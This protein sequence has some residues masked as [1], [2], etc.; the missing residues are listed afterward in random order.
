LVHVGAERQ[1]IDYGRRLKHPTLHG[2][3]S[4]AGRVCAKPTSRLAAIQ[5]HESSNV[6]SY[7]VLRGN[8]KIVASREVINFGKIH[9]VKTPFRSL[10][11]NT[12]QPAG[13]LANR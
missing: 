2:L 13:R 12:I 8:G 10:L 6:S 5:E 9:A 11:T 7:R 1:M 3:G 4:S